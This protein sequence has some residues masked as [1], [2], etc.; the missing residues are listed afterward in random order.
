M[1]KED[2]ENIKD[3]AED[4]GGEALEKI[5]NAATKIS[6][7]TSNIGS[8][9]CDY[10]EDNPWKAVAIGFGLGFLLAKFTNRNCD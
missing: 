4:M 5:K 1:A 6:D 9:I 2:F 7:K 3:K 10:V 8:G